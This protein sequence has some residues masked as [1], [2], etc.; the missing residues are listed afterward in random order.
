MKRSLS[1]TIIFFLGFSLKAEAQTYAEKLGWEAGQKLL[2][3]HVD[4]AGMSYDSNQG[5]IQA[6]EKGIANSVSIMMPCPWAAS[7]VKYAKDHPET[8]AGLHLTLTSEWKDYRWHPLS[9]IPA[10]PGLVD[11]E[12]AMWHTVEQV[13]THASPDEVEQEIRQQVERA[14]RLGYRPTH[15]DSHMGTLFATEEFIRRYVKVGVDYDIPVMIPGGHN[16]LL[17]QGYREQGIRRLREAGKYKEGMEVPLPEAV[18]KA[19]TVGEMVWKAGLPVLDDLHTISGD[20]ALPEGKEKNE[21][22]IH[23]L[24]VQKFKELF[25]NMRPGVTMVI[26]HCTDPTEVFP[27]ISGSG[28]S[29]KGDLLAMMD[30]RLKQYLKDNNIQLTTWR[31]LKSRRGRLNK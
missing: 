12:G 20:W 28:L 18:S 21:Q 4:D 14:L 23:E 2:I 11:G 26:V 13:A 31:E 15:L 9:G 29:R 8:D 17:R 6:M 30:P 10:V 16:T 3:M 19:E 25:E 24:K 7:F 22:N 1:I 5:A 27:K